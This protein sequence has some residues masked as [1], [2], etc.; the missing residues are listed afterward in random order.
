MT[1]DITVLLLTYGRPEML[2]ES[3]QCFLRQNYEHKRL[4]I[5]NDDDRVKYVFDHPD[6]EIF[7]TP[8]RR[9]CLPQVI[10]HAVMDLVRTEYFTLYE[11]DDILLPWGLSMMVSNMSNGKFHMPVGRWV[12]SDDM[13]NFISDPVSTF[14]C[15]KQYFKEIGGWPFHCFDEKYFHDAA[16][17][18]P[19][20]S[21]LLTP[22]ESYFIYRF[23]ADQYHLS[24]TRDPQ[25]VADQVEKDIPAG[26][27]HIEPAWQRDY[28]QMVRDAAAKRGWCG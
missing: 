24:G 14:L 11:D 19:R 16:L 28:V 21:G 15:S 13:L 2:N 3:V 5:H 9:G 6:V 12:M 8:R 17:S 23:M 10:N 20:S 18:E 4:L 27:Y 7:N 1:I 25:A 26:T 22:Y